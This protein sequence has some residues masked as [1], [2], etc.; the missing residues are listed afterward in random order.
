MPI[1]TKIEGNPESIRSATEWIRGSLAKQVQHVTSQVFSVRNR[2]ESGWHGEAGGAFTHKM[3]TGGRQGDDFHEAILNSAAQADDVA[4]ALQGAQREMGRIRSEAAEAG[5]RVQGET[6]L[7]P[8]PAPADPG[9]EPSG[10]DATP[11]AMSA[12]QDAVQAQQDHARQTAAYDKAKTEAEDTQR[13]WKQ[14]VEKSTEAWQKLKGRSIFT[15]AGLGVSGGTTAMM[16]HRS[17]L[18]KDA[19]ELKSE[20]SRMAARA[21]P[22]YYGRPPAGMYD[23]LDRAAQNTRSAAAQEARAA[24]TK[25]RAGKISFRAGGVLAAGGIAYDIANGKPADQAIVSGGAGFAASVGAGALAGT[26]IGGPVGTAVGA[27]AGVAVGAFTS[28]AVDSLY[29]NGVGA[30][31]TAVEDGGQAVLDTGSAI[32]GLAKDTGSA[33]AGGVKDAWDAVF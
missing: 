27:V 13:V 14:Q 4:A 26:A 28:G 32:G 18:L 19:Q 29:E 12:H 17:I 5:L 31:G 10:A 24:D 22:D 8:E 20:A 3:T 25:S 7:E 1:N 9:P 11:E 33:V 21:T 15:V 2:A 30:I 6:I 23:D 16:A